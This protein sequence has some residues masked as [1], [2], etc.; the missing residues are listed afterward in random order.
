MKEI[1]IT[2]Y[3][4]ISFVRNLDPKFEARA[5]PATPN[6]TINTY[7]HNDVE[8]A[9][10]LKL[11]T[12]YEIADL[13]I[14]INP[15]D[16]LIINNKVPH[17]NHI[18]KE[19]SL[20]IILFISERYLN[21]MIIES[22]FDQSIIDL[23]IALNTKRFDQ[24]IKMNDKLISLLTEM[25]ENLQDD[26]PINP[27]KQKLLIG[28]FI[29]ELASLKIF[30]EFKRHRQ[31]NDLL[32]YI[33]NNLKTAS[34][35]EYADILKYSVSFTSKKIKKDYNTS[36]MDILHTI[37]IQAATRLLISTDLKIESIMEKI[38]YSNKTHF[39]NLFKEKNYLTPHEFRS[40]HKL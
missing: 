20:N 2:D 33:E 38:G 11:S 31:E 32:D 12:T 7:F 6:E 25:N 21:N 29:I 4:D 17:R 16:L 9:C 37:R 22:S 5:V 3:N 27:H 35:T 34:L 13:V 15:G 18:V 14:T 24:T 10:Q 26:L 39:Y 8:I 40:K 36:F 28:L 30:T 19:G 1:E 23:C